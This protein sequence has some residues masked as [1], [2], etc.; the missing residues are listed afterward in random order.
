MGRGW[1]NTNAKVRV[2]PKDVPEDVERVYKRIKKY[3]EACM[4]HEYSSELF[5]YRVKHGGCHP[6]RFHYSPRI[7]KLHRLM[8]RLVRYQ[9]SPE[10][11]LMQLELIRRM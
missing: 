10:Y 2:S 7:R 3:T 6:K 4:Q 1:K 5:A 8:T 11:A 9:T